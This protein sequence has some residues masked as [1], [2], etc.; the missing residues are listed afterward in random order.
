VSSLEI[1]QWILILL[2]IL[3]LILRWR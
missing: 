3:V 1:I 2:I